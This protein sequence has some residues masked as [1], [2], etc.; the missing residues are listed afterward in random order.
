VG[1]Q[2]KRWAGLICFF[3]AVCRF[4]SAA[5][6]VAAGAVPEGEEE[7]AGDSGG[8]SGAAA[9]QS[10]RSLI[11]LQGQ[12]SHSSGRS[13]QNV[14]ASNTASE[15]RARRRRGQGDRIA[16]P[17]S[18]RGGRGGGRSRG[19]SRST[20]GMARLSA[21]SASSSSMLAGPGQ[22][23]LDHGFHL[24]LGFDNGG[25]S[26]GGGGLHSAL[27]LSHQQ[28]Q[29]QRLQHPL[30]PTHMAQALLT[31]STR[32]PLSRGGD[33]LNPTLEPADSADV[34]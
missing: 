32:Q 28:L 10:I 4:S 14:R 3:S 27:A 7:M 18:R 8:D 11:S 16:K 9:S 24:G 29:Q 23:E 22:E 25:G 26:G 34:S 1:K 17:Q 15:P 30:N 12:H 2:G 13:G 5:A 20:T 21:S 33:F 6:A 19:G 31:T